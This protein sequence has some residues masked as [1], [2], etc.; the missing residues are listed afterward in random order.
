M[1]TKF[2]PSAPARGREHPHHPGSG[3]RIRKPGDALFHRQGFLGDAAPGPEGLLS[4]QA[5]VSAAACRH[6]LEIPRDDRVPRPDGPR[7][8]SRP[9]DPHQPGRGAPGDQPV[10]PR[11]GTAHRRDEDRGAEAGA[12]PV[13]VRRG[14]RRGPPRRGE[15][16]G[17]GTDLLLPHRH[18][19]L[20]SEEP[21][22]G[23]VEP[24]QHPGQARGEHPRVS[25]VQLD[26]T[27]CL[28]VHPPRKHPDRPALLCQGAAGGGARRH[29][30][31]GR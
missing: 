27:G 10:R 7:A 18:P 11:F 22:P 21:A 9:A 14:F 5:A 13:Q 24:L 30:D 2:D 4:G 17:Q 15:V 3:G 26:R 28:A 25:P 8:R 19:S 31:H 20:G 6:H 23:A 16:A 1:R 12:R 29:A